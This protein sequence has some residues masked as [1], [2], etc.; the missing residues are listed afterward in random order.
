MNNATAIFV[1]LLLFSTTAR[2]DDPK[3][4]PQPVIPKPKP[5]RD[6]EVIGPETELP[7]D[8]MIKKPPDWL[9][10]ESIIAKPTPPDKLR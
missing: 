3:P 1:S 5:P 8:P 10:D 4:T 9:P 7:P 2:A 6:P